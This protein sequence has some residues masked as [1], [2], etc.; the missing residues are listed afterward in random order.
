MTEFVPPLSPGQPKYIG[1]LLGHSAGKMYARDSKM[2]STLASIDGEHWESV[3]E[4]DVPATLDPVMVV[5]G[6][7]TADTVSVTQ[8]AYEGE[9]VR[10]TAGLRG[11]S[12]R[13]KAGLPG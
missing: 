11:E 4:A 10:H 13:H 2:S 7:T 5:K 12:V 6:T 8:G 1:Q 9:S 3:A